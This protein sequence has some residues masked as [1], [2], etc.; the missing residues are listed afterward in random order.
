MRH[1]NRRRE[2][3]AHCRLRGGDVGYL[4][5]D[6]GYLD[7]RRRQQLGPLQLDASHPHMRLVVSQPTRCP[8]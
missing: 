1:A 4:E 8:V 6:A 7:G 2:W 3:V 5:F